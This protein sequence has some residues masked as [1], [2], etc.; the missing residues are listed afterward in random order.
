[1]RIAAGDSTR[2][3][4]PDV[5]Q[6]LE[7]IRVIAQARDE[8]GIRLET[9]NGL[10]IWEAQPRIRHQTAVNRIRANVV[11]L[12]SDDTR[13]ECFV[14]NEVLIRFPNGSLK[15]PDISI[16][17]RKPEEEDRTITVT[18]DAIVEVIS[19]RYEAKD[20]VIGPP[21]YISQG[22]RDVIVFDPTSLKISHF[23]KD[24]TR[25]YLSPT[26]ISLECGCI[27]SI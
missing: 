27:C 18:P 14:I 19:P 8:L 16:F 9:A 3:P 2:Y 4:L 22:V 15:T 17:C 7:T 21:F 5:E 6:I 20:L 12:K 25:E 10:S 24:V 11:R 13:C 26:T 23:R 1:L